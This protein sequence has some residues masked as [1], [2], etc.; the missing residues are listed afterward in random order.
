MTLAEMMQTARVPGVTIASLDASGEI[1]SETHGVTNVENAAQQDEVRPDTV[2]GAAS[3]SKVAFSYL[4][5][6]LID[7]GVIPHLE[8][9][10]PFGLGSSLTDILPIETFYK[11][12]MKQEFNPSDI[13]RT[14]AITTEMIL[15]HQSGL[16]DFAAK[17]DFEPGTEFGYSGMGLI[18]LQQVIEK[19]TGETL[20]DLAKQYMFNLPDGVGMTNSSFIPPTHMQAINESEETLRPPIAASSLFT[21]ASDFAKLMSAWMNDSSDIMQSAFRPRVQMT[22]DQWAIARSVDESDLSHVAWGLGIGLELDDT[23]KAI[24]AFHTGDMN[25]WRAWVAMDLESKSGTVYCANGQDDRHAYGHVLSETIMPDEIELKHAMNWFYKKYGFARDTSEGWESNEKENMIIISEYLKSR[26]QERLPDSAK[27]ASSTAKILKE[28][29]PRL[30]VKMHDTPE[31]EKADEKHIDEPS[32]SLE[33][34]PAASTHITPTP[35]SK[36]LTPDKKK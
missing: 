26:A 11:E 28:M 10:S 33:T 23:G 14:K 30:T 1:S 5:L 2:F 16:S 6:K 27:Q 25:Q 21:T 15:A 36:T 31:Q 18:Y 24:T 34:E 8:N 4:V 19:M 17:L 32:P 22:R 35:F 29:T 13:E 12:T 7:K 20:E 9:D 3:L